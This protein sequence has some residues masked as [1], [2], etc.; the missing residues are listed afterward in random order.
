MRGKCA[1]RLA[2]AVVHLKDLCILG[3]GIER[4]FKDSTVPKLLTHEAAQL[5]LVHDRLGEDIA[6][7]RKC[8]GDRWDF[9]FCIYIWCS[10]F[11]G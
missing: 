10:N 5:R 2:V 9:L 1:D 3:I 11:L 4:R 8:V 6:C 7:T